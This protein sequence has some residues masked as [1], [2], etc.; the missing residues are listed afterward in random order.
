LI[1]ELA[2]SAI[3]TSMTVTKKAKHKKHHH[4]QR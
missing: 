2:A 3:T 1:G 4:V